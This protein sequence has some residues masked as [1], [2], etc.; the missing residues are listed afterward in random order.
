MPAAPEQLKDDA[1]RQAANLAGLSAPL[2]AELA[3][4]AGKRFLAAD[5]ELAV[6]PFAEALPE[7]AFR[8]LGAAHPAAG[9]YTI[10]DEKDVDPEPLPGFN[11]W[12][13]ESFNLTLQIELTR[14]RPAVAAK[15][16][17]EAGL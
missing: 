4:F 2:R 13:P 14:K 5:G 17:R 11:P 1:A 16:K 7:W 10:P 6:H 12:K 3:K 15:L 9:W 8:E